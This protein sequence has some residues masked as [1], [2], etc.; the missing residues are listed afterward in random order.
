MA[1][2]SPLRYP[3]GKGKLANYIKLI[4]RYN[5]LMDGHY[6]EPYA[7]GSAVA[8]QL[9]FDEYVTHIHVN[10]VSK[11][12]FS[13]WHSVIHQ[14]EDLCNLIQTTNITIDEWHK[15]KAIQANSE[16]ISLLKLGFSTFFLNRTNRSGI[17]KGGVIGG[18]KQD[19]K[20]KLNARFNKSNLLRRIKRIARYKNRISLYNDDAAILI[21]RLDSELQ[22]K[23]L[24]YLDPPY[25][26]KGKGLY[27]NYYEHT[28]HLNI[29]QLITGLKHPWV[30]SYDRTA[31]IQTMYNHFQQI[32]YSLN[33]S[34][35]EH[36]TSTEV[37][38]FS[39]ILCVP[40][41]SNPTS[42]NNNEL[43]TFLKNE[44]PFLS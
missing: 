25:Y 27:I 21:K 10:D 7:G 2:V 13:F 17:L 18:K 1:F 3:G 41:V 34:A 19:G 20:Y 33:Y 44:Q 15:Q 35:A 39:D 6:I 40:P 29:S 14:T 37:M 9:L 12:I 42:I 26:K 30:V 28:D 38:Y 5:N 16:N 23:V 22:N 11:P 4:F 32:S 31:E 8:L 43:A 24:F 36:I